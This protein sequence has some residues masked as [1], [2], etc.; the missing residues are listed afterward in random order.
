MNSYLKEKETWKTTAGYK[1]LQELENK[2]A[3]EKNQLHC[4]QY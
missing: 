2:A 3:G 1:T 4:G